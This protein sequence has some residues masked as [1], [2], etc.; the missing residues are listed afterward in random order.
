MAEPRRTASSK[1]RHEAR[2][3]DSSPAHQGGYVAHA[4][5]KRGGG[6]KC[7]CCNVAEVSKGE[8]KEN[9]RRAQ[10]LERRRCAATCAGTMAEPR[11]TASSKP[12]LEAW[13]SRQLP[14]QPRRICGTRCPVPC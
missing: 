7:A 13:G 5:L 14:G 8:R 4:A 6:A 2:G 9:G 10:G 1:T 12:C 3:H 11:R